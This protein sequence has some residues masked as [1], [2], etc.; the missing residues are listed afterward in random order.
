[1]GG[2]GGGGERPGTVGGG[3]LVSPDGEATGLAGG[4]PVSS[5]ATRSAGAL[6][7]RQGAGTRGRV[8]VPAFGGSGVVLCPGKTPG[9]RSSGE[10]GGDPEGAIGR[11]AQPGRTRA[12]RGL[13][14]LLSESHL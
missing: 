8:V 9:P 2:T 13:Q 1:S 6:V 10:S 5:R 14:S 3:D 12:G 4:T 11:T 7:P